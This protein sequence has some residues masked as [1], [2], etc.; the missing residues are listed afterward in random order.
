MDTRLYRAYRTLGLRPG[1]APEEV[2]QA[3]RDLAQVWHPDRFGDNARLR[4]KAN[5]NLQRINE[6]YEVLRDYTPP[7]DL[8]VSRVTASLSAI[9]DL[10]DL[11]QGAPSDRPSPMPRRPRTRPR[12]TILGLD[13]APPAERPVARTL[14]RL[15]LMLVMVAVIALV[16]ALR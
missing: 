3:H 11:M 4:D 16:F 7:A 1:A 15:T 9:L 6:A 14:V 10:G 8:R 12:R 2:R 13:L 5:R